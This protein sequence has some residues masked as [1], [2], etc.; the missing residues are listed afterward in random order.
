MRIQT[1]RFG[2]IEVNEND[3]V[4]FPEGIIGFSGVKRYVL[5]TQGSD[6]PFLWL[7]S[8]DR[9]DLA[10]VVMDPLVAVPDYRV[11]VEPGE[12]DILDLKDLKDARILSIVVIPPGN[13]K[14]MRTNLRGPIVINPEKRVA[15][16][17]VLSEKYPLRYSLCGEGS[18]NACPQP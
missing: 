12:I 14:A 9:P 15:R 11:E 8:I 3:V 13:V 2:E 10:F 1:S 5:V 18:M 16:Q 6:S 17:I 4:T 7:Q